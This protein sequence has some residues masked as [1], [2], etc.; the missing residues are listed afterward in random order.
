MAESAGPAQVY[1]S[2]PLLKR[3]V[4]A[5]KL[6]VI[7]AILSLVGFLKHRLV[8]NKYPPDQVKSYECRPKLPIRYCH[9]I[10]LNFIMSAKARQCL[11]PLVIL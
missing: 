11:L 3:I 10:A 8:Q 7:K 9:L 2:P 4:F 5:T 6:S 1:K